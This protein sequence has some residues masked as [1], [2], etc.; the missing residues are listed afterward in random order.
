M[1]M[2]PRQL[3]T[4]ACPCRRC[5]N[6]KKKTFLHCKCQSL[7]SRLKTSG[8]IMGL[9]RIK[10]VS[11]TYQSRM[12]IVLYAAHL[13]PEH[14]PREKIL[15]MTGWLKLAAFQRWQKNTKVFVRSVFAI[16]ATNAS[17]LRVN[18]NLQIRF[19]IICNMYY[20]IVDFLPK[21]HC[22]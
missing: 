8:M 3:C 12:Q 19:S 6:Y 20:V 5:N 14:A 21:K 2:S 13:G 15:P 7:N 22:F 4:V 9:P 18:A 17:F 16:F 1:E 11:P 10:F